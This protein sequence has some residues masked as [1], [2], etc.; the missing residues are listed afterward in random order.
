MNHIKL[1][2]AVMTFLCSFVFLLFGIGGTTVSATESEPIDT[3]DV[4]ENPGTDS[5]IA[6]IY[7]INEN[8]NLYYIEISGAGRMKDFSFS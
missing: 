7:K 1:N 5:V 8:L 3:W 2:F 4:S 6:E